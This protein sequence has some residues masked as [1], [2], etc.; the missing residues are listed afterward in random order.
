MPAE[1]PGK[2]SGRAHVSADTYTAPDWGTPS[3]SPRAAGSSSSASGAAGS[4]S[5]AP[6]PR[7]LLL[8]R[9]PARIPLP[10]HPCPSPPPLLTP[11]R[12]GRHR[13][14]IGSRQ[15]GSLVLS[16]ESLMLIPR[17]HKGLGRIS[18]SH[19]KPLCT[20]AVWV[21]GAGPPCPPS[22]PLASR[23]GRLNSFA[24]V[25]DGFIIYN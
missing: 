16:G 23:V 15:E 10:H 17:T 24:H 21:E 6:L 25:R 11:C 20:P 22:R 7:E 13:G 18:R 8:P 5:S 3:T 14:F 9:P 4:S 1:Q 2:C 19:S 12:R